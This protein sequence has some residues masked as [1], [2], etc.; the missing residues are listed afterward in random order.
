MPMR[1][2]PSPTNP[3][4]QQRRLH[5]TTTPRHLLLTPRHP[6]TSLTRH[7]LHGIIPHHKVLAEWQALRQRGGVAAAEEEERELQGQYEDIVL[8]HDVLV[9]LFSS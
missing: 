2:L 7:H 4:T 5:V 9:F 6:T 8:M 3:G 1:H